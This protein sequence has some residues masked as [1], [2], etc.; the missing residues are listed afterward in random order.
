MQAKLIYLAGCTSNKRNGS[1][2]ETGHDYKIVA[3]DLIDNNQS[4]ILVGGIASKTFRAR[5][6]LELLSH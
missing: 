5:T 2:K 4:F 1:G 6:S 3:L